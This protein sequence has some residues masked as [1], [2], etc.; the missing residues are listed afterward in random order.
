[1]TQRLSSRVLY[2]IAQRQ[3]AARATFID[4]ADDRYSYRSLVDDIQTWCGLLDAREVGPGRSVLILTCDDR[5]AIGAFVAA[6]LDGAIPTILAA[7]A[8]LT[9]VQAIAELTHAKLVVA[10]QSS[11]AGQDWL[12]SE[13]LIAVP[14]ARSNGGLFARTR[15]ANPL[16]DLA[17]NATPRPPRC[18]AKPDDLAYIVFTSGTTSA[19]KGVM[20]THRNLFT[21]LETLMRVFGHDETSAI[22]DGLALAHVDGLVQGPLQVLANGA[23]LV[24]PPPFTPQTLDRYL[25]LVRAKGATHFI[26]VPTIYRFIDRYGLHDDYF[27]AEEFV[28][29][30]S[31]AS[32]LD[33]AL[34]RRLEQR[35]GKPVYNM[36]GLT[37]TVTGGLYAGPG[38]ELGGF[39]SIGKPIDMEVRLMRADGGPAAPGEEGEMWLRGDNVSPG[40]FANATATAE[41]YADGWFKTGDLAICR[42]DGAYEIRGRVATA[43]V[44]G[45]LT[46]NSDELNE[47]LLAHPAVAEATTV[48]LPDDN[49]GEIAVSAVVLDKHADELELTE[50]C[51]RLLEPRKVPKRIIALPSIPRGDAGKP[52]IGPLREL[53]AARIRERVNGSVAGADLAD[54]ILQVA[55]QTFRVPLAELSLDSS[56]ETVKRW[57]SFGHVSLILNVEQSL[58]KRI[59]TADALG[60][61]TLR[62]LVDVVRRAS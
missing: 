50:H 56:P 41:K 51:G 31:S 18:E 24:R 38:R 10:D 4:W 46:I 11:P 16:R 62:Q 60:I 36:Y 21:H 57:D 2:G 44:C 23:R 37:E 29:L 48:G 28:G 22:F 34:W 61:D 13:R 35:F 53:L 39:G 3:A 32:K 8:P 14:T 12:T 26:G 55:S 54:T 17:R 1:M 52:Q 42:A 7:D 6:M 9:R 19:P 45:G 25:N 49:F 58:Q 43:I 5:V 27:E 20:I 40:Y 47:A 59:A 30:V 15:A 33:E